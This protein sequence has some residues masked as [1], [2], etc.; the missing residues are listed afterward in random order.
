MLIQ[1]QHHK[2]SQQGLS[3]D[4]INWPRLKKTG[5]SFITINPYLHCIH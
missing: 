4:K 5:A 2:I 3:N 1:Q